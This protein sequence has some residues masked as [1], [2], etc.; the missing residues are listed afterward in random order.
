MGEREKERERGVTQSKHVP[1]PATKDY[2]LGEENVVVKASPRSSP[3]WVHCSTFYLFSR[4]R[5]RRALSDPKGGAFVN[6][7]SVR[8]DNGGLII[9]IIV[10]ARPAAAFR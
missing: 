2:E 9:E 8:K 4:G 5:K 6:V 1:T 7:A 3:N 10:A